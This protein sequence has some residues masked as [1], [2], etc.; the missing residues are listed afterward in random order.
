MRFAFAVNAP[1]I[2]S[3]FRGKSIS[4]LN[5]TQGRLLSESESTFRLEVV[6]HTVPCWLRYN[7]YQQ[8][9]LIR[10][11]YFCKKRGLTMIDTI[12]PPLRLCR[13]NKKISKLC[14]MQARPKDRSMAYPL[15][16]QYSC[17]S[18]VWYFA[19]LAHTQH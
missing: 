9:N 3:S 11:I 14:R 1:K 12:R 10:S 8:E 15:H 6:L 17:F 4:C 2:A 16:L 18:S 5:Q 19:V 13:E 7:A